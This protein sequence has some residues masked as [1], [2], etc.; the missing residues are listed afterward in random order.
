MNELAF[1]RNQT[2]PPGEP[3]EAGCGNQDDR[4]NKPGGQQC[5][6][7]VSHPAGLVSG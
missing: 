3:L 7:S 6:Q 2:T 1:D 5:Q 4:G